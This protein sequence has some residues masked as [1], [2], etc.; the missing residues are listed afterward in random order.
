MNTCA[1]VQMILQIVAMIVICAYLVHD[2]VEFP[3]LLDDGGLRKVARVEVV[4]VR[5]AAGHRPRR[6]YRRSEDQRT[7]RPPWRLKEVNNEP[8]ILRTI[9]S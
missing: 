7:W 8:V 4:L 9:N 2:L 1:Y 3:L 6:R 5:D